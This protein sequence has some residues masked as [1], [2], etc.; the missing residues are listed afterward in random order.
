MSVKLFQQPEINSPWVLLLLFLFVFL[1]LCSEIYNI[2]KYSYRYVDL[3]NSRSY[4]L[5][6]RF[7]FNVY[8]IPYVLTD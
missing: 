6:S 4:I 7:S 3:L 8:C 1:I 2:W 5:D